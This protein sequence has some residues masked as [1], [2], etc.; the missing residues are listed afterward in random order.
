MSDEKN[1]AGYA[2]V[3]MC[4][5]NLKKGDTAWAKIIVGEKDV[6]FDCDEG[7]RW[8]DFATSQLSVP[9]RDIVR[10]PVPREVV[11]MQYEVLLDDDRTRPGDIVE[12]RDGSAYTV[13][14]TGL[15]FTVKDACT[16]VIARVLRPIKK[17]P[18]KKP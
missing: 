5:A 12:Y 10:A 6:A 3:L 9:V 18:I 11:T 8:T 7:C 2:T 14:V 17:R 13:T 15:T 1:K 16:E 4:D